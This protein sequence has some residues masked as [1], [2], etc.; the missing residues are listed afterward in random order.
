MMGGGG[1]YCTAQNA[2]FEIGLWLAFE[3]KLREEFQVFHD[4]NLLH[5]L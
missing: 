3:F 1:D 2:L 4:F 5:L